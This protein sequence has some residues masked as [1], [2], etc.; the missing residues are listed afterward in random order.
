LRGG[1]NSS[2]RQVKGGGEAPVWRWAYSSPAEVGA[3]A[4]VF[5][6]ELA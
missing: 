5:L 3:I 2:S 4:P 6:V 1:K